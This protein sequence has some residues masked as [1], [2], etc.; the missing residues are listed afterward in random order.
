MAGA[1]QHPVLSRSLR[2]NRGLHGTV[3]EG[4]RGE[5]HQS[6]PRADGRQAEG[7]LADLQPSNDVE[8]PL[9][10]DSLEV[11]KKLTP[12]AHHHEQTA[13]TGKILGML[14]EMIREMRNSPRQ[15]G[16]LNLG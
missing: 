6:M 15:K 14:L 12:T 5:P 2:A 1:E 10:S 11:V 4:T 13:A 9:R 7:L 3:N 8:I 16:D